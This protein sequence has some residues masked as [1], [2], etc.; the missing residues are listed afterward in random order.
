MAKKINTTVNMENKTVQP[1]PAVGT[2]P[3]VSIRLPRVEGQSQEVEVGLNGR[4]Y[5]IRRGSFISVPEPILHILRNAGMAP[6]QL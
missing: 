6:E 3:R 4:L 1:L 2:G 5:I